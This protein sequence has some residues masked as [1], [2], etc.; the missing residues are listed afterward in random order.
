MRITQTRKAEWFN[1][2]HDEESGP[3]ELSNHVLKVRNAM[4]TAINLL[5]EFRFMNKSTKSYDEVAKII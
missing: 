1:L 4:G 3:R 2:A 5:D